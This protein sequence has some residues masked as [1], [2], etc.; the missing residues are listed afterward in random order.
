[1]EHLHDLGKLLF[2]FIVFWAYIGFSQFFLI[3]YGNIPEETSW[4]LERMHGSW[5]PYTVGLACGHFALPFLFLMSRNVK[6]RTPL[7]VAG[8]TWMLLMH[9]GDLHW[10]V[11]PNL[12]HEGFGPSLLDLSTFLGVGGTCLAWIGWQLRGH[13]LLPVR[14]PLL[15][16]SLGF[17]NA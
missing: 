15:A 11:M 6:R 17:E 1:V 14:D 16:E 4:Y 10:L 7:L 3:W 13:A 5:K 12:H 9:F 8:A 2:A